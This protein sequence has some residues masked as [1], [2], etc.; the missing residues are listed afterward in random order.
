MLTKATKLT[1]TEVD[2]A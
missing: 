1:S 2:F